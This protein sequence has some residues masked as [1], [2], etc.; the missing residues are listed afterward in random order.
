SLTHLSITSIAL[1][2]PATC[3]SSTSRGRRLAWSGTKRWFASRRVAAS[4][5]ILDGGKAR[6]RPKWPH[7]HYKQRT[8]GAWWRWYRGGVG[9]D[10]QGDHASHQNHANENK[11]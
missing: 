3:S 4:A 9:H 11:D 10:P 2:S 5:G 1:F 6:S 8:A 7:V